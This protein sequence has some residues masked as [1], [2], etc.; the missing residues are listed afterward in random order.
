MR[1]TESYER[2]KD[3]ADF[4]LIYLR[5]AHASDGPRPARHVEIEQPQDQATRNKIAGACSE[6]LK[7]PMPVLVDDMQDTVGKAFHAH[8]DRLFIATA[9]GTI[10]YRGERG[11]RGFDV[12]DMEK[13]LERL[14]KPVTDAPR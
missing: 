4:Y 11:P 6:A 3:R 1:L 14:L 2:Y 5:E 9:E 10:A 12:A 13:A 8:P 7:L